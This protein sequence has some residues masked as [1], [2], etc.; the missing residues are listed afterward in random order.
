MA[1]PLLAIKTPEGAP[2]PGA[3]RFFLIS[4]SECAFMLWKMR[5]RRLL[6]SNNDTRNRI[7][8]P[9]EIK[10]QLIAILNNR[11]ELDRTLTNNIKYKHNALPHNLVLRTWNG[12]L[13][14]KHRLPDNWLSVSG[15][16]VGIANDPHGSCQ[17]R[18]AGIG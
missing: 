3:T 10:N 1:L 2:R 15:V 14:N 7:P 18:C 16:L 6:D 4:A 8:D 13:T 5:C 12:T 11:P 17:R 9:L